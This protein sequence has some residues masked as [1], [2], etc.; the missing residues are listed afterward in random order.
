[1]PKSSKQV[2]AMKEKMKAKGGGSSPKAQAMPMPMS[3]R[4]S[5][6]IEKISNGYLTHHSRET[7]KGYESTTTFHATKPQLLAPHPKKEK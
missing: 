1:M 2:A 6:R 7:N 4:E 3:E 5:V